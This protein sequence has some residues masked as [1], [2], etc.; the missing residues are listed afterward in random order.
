MLPK[1]RATLNDKREGRLQNE[2]G[3]LSYVKKEHG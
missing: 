3:F 2:I 1:P